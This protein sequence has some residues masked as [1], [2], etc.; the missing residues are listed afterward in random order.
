MDETTELQL[1]DWKMTK[2]RIKHFDDVIM[3]TRVGGLPIATGL[4][5][6]AFLTSDTIGKIHPDLIPINISI[7]SLIMLSSVLYIIPVFLFDILHFQLLIKAVN[8]ARE[9]EASDHFKGKLQITTKL[10]SHK[11]T[12]IHR[13]AGFAIYVAIMITGISFAIIGLSLDVQDESIIEP[14]TQN[15]VTPDE[16]T[17]HKL[18]S[19]STE[20]FSKNVSTVD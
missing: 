5:T 9:I 20:Q 3:R 1:E 13:Y 11:L 19:N 18:F 4:Q 12:V 2:D 10:T 14:I 8:H 16:L 17:E 6:V 15:I 7:F